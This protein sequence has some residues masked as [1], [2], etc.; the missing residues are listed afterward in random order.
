M[1]VI[2]SR[3]QYTTLICC[4][5][6]SLFPSRFRNKFKPWSFYSGIFPRLLLCSIRI[7]H[8]VP[9]CWKGSYLHMQQPKSISSKL[10]GLCRKFFFQLAKVVFNLLPKITH[11]SWFSDNLL[12]PVMPS[13]FGLEREY[14]NVI[15]CKMP[16][17][18]SQ[19]I[20]S[21]RWQI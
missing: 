7:E 6:S 1:L 15:R 19:V 12:E 14:Q 20:L 11:F 4:L 16:C 2:V 10:H 5:T 21:H 17:H 3:F 8:H 18:F 13:K 9:F